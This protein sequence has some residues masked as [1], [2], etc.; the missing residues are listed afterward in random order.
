M[1]SNTLTCITAI[2]LFTALAMPVQLV[3]QHTRYNHAQKK[4]EKRAWACNRAA[5]FHASRVAPMCSAS[6]VYAV[7]SKSGKAFQ[8]S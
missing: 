7:K 4:S 3:A 2:A 6:T 1:K 8:S 5:A